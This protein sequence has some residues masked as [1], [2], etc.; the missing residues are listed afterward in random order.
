MDDED[1]ED[2]KSMDL[3]RG[4]TGGIKT[5]EFFLAPNGSMSRRGTSTLLLLLDDVEEDRLLFLF[6]IKFF[7]C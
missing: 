2:E 3:L 6:R 4:N 7:T 5:N 1:E